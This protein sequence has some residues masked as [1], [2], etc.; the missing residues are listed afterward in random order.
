M[1]PLSDLL[2][3]DSYYSSELIF[4][5]SQK[6]FI[7]E[8]SLLTRNLF[9]PPDPLA[10]LWS[11]PRMPPTLPTPNPSLLLPSLSRPYLSWHCSVFVLFYYYYFFNSSCFPVRW[12][13]PPSKPILGAGVLLLCQ[14]LV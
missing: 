8:F 7:L 13:V 6:K 12:L 10:L 3:L 4:T 11:L 9:P 2:C 14:H 5:S 1:L